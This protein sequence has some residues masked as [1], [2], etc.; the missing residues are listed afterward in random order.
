MKIQN[1]GQ[2][3]V[4]RYKLSGFLE[5]KRKMNPVIPKMIAMDAEDIPLAKSFLPLCNSA[6]H[7]AD[8]DFKS[9]FL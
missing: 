4:T 6:W 1:S 5:S 3:E 9:S 2:D 8:K 7:A